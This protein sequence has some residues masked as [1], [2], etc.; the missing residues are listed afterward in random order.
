MATLERGAR[1]SGRWTAALCLATVATFVGWYGPLQIL[2]G[3]QADLIAPLS[4][5]S[6]LALV[7]GVGAACS[8]VA[9]PLWGALSDRT[10]G[11]WGKRAP[12]VLGGAV[13][14]AGGLALL[15]AADSVAGMVLGWS[16]AQIALNAPFAALSAAIPDQVPVERRGTAGGYFGLAQTAGIMGGTGLA[17][18]GGT[19]LSGYLACAVAVLLGS[20][21]F[22]LLRH[23]VV[24]GP[25]PPWD[26]GDF[27]RGFWVNPLRHRDFGWAWLTRFLINLGNA[28]ALLYLLYYLQDEVRIADPA[29]GVFVLTAVYAVALLGTVLVGGVLSDRLGRRRAFVCWSGVIMSVASVLLAGWPTWTGAVVAAAVLGVGFGTYTSV[30]FAL[31]TEVLPAAADR[32]RHLG[33]INI[34]NTLPQVLAPVLAAP[35]VAHLGG[36]PVLYLTAAAVG[37][38]GAVLVYRI[39]SV[40]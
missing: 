26:L 4:K 3:K 5:E 11:R 15:A 25:R 2:L 16:V 29:G 17:L 39:E 22:A 37:L 10:T 21:P 18:V 40:R 14:G 33:V 1:V 30:D 9:N 7:A 12:W 24:P 13:A 6:V 34:A 35:I 38:L 36:Y 8:M 32:G 27:L 20:L 28:V 31:V 19:V 23:E